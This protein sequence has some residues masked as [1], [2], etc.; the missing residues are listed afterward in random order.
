MVDFNAGETVTTPSWNVLK[1]LALE[2]RENLILAIEFYFKN[3][4]LGDNQD[5]DV[6]MIR[7][8]LWC[9]YYEL[10][11]WLIRSRTAREIQDFKEFVNH[12]KPEKVLEAVSFIN[13]FMDEKNLTK[14][15]NIKTIDRTRV[16][17]END[18]DDY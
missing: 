15:D 7:T 2:K 10:E 1:I 9:I 4:Y 16:E 13:K 8:R 11:A 14:I 3:K 6:D 12:D 5:H 17:L 18:N